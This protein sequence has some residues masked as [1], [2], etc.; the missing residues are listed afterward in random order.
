LWWAGKSKIWGSI[1]DAYESFDPGVEGDSGVINRSIG[2]GP[3]DNIEWMQSMGRL[4]IGTE[5]R[6]LQAK[7]SSLE[8]PLTP[9]NFNLRDISGQ[10]SAPIQGVKLDKRVLFTQKAGVRVMETGYSGQTLDY[11][12]GDHTKL[13]PE[14]GEPGL[15]RM[16]VQRQPDTRLHCVRGATDGTVGLLVTDP[17]ED[18]KAWV[19]VESSGGVNGIIEEVA[20]LPAAGEDAVYY[21]VKREIDGSTK[22]YLE[23]WATEWDAIV[24]LP[25]QTFDWTT[26]PDVPPL[27]D[28]LTIQPSGY[29]GWL[30]MYWDH[31]ATIENVGLYS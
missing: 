13:I 12:T 26:H 16:A 21:I 4:I 30:E 24:A 28:R 25:L 22:R 18:V 14:I 10:G 11:E 29:I 8:E 6:E 19:D 20:V 5:D 7:T 9:T 27:P 1:S 3:V 2:T 23:R 15:S 17:L 31:L